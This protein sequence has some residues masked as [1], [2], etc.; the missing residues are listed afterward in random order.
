MKKLLFSLTTT[1]SGSIAENRLPG[2]TI[3]IF[4]AK[5]PR[6]H[7]VNVGFVGPGFPKVPG[8]HDPTRP[9]E[10][11]DPAVVVNYSHSVTINVMHISCGKPVDKL[12]IPLYILI[13]Q[14]AYM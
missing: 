11:Q 1:R 4:L 3:F 13:L 10:S 9:T 8:Q 12:L 7:Y 2:Y 14:T 5:V 6:I